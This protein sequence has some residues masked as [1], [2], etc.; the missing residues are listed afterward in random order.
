MA[1]INISR[2]RR[3]IK[4]FN[5]FSAFSGHTCSAGNAQEGRPGVNPD[6]VGAGGHEH[7]VALEEL[8]HGI[9]AEH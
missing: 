1:L 7:A 2:V 4:F 5:H 9:A 3:F 8:Q 6:I